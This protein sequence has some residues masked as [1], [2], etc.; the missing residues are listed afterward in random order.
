MCFPSK[1]LKKNFSE[2]D[3]TEPSGSKSTTT[4][5]KPTSKPADKPA[6][7]PTTNDIEVPAT[8]GPKTFKTAIVIYTMY[9][10]I[11]S[12]ESLR[13]LCD[14][15]VNRHSQTGPI[16]SL[17]MAVFVRQSESLSDN[18]PLFDRSQCNQPTHDHLLFSPH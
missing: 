18:Q 12:R 2:G 3:K 1:W 11:A 17:V 7:K 15:S 6:A 10:H 8:K 4:T 13:S 16:M 14:L 5:E 9:G